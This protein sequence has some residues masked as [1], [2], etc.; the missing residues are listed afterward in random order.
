MCFRCPDSAPT[1]RYH[2]NSKLFRFPPILGTEDRWP[3]AECVCATAHGHHC[4]PTLVPRRNP[5][6]SCAQGCR[7]PLCMAPLCL[8]LVHPGFSFSALARPGL[9]LTRGSSSEYCGS[10]LVC[11]KS[12]QKGHVCLP[13][14]KLSPTK[15]LQLQ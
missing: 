7:W 15:R 10:E 11:V 14:V 13:R 5:C 4:T 2:P 1:L 6:A 8:I 12:D 3:S 9:A